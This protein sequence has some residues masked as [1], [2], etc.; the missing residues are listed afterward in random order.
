LVKGKKITY[1][2]FTGILPISIGIIEMY[3]Y[4]NTIAISV[5][6]ILTAVIGSYFTIIVAKH[7][8]FD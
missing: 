2:F 1:G 6:Y 5:G 7:L 8:K 3:I 4:H